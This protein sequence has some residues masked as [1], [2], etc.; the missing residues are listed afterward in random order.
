VLRSTQ[1]AHVSAS[2]ESQLSAPL[3]E[4]LSPESRCHGAT[5][6]E[7]AETMEREPSLRSTEELLGATVTQK[8]LPEP[9]PS[10]H[11]SSTSVK[12]LARLLP[13]KLA[14][15]SEAKDLHSQATGELKDATPT[16]L[17]STR[18]TLTMAELEEEMSGLGEK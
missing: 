4:L 2:P 18:D 11:Q 8:P 7:A 13:R 17:E 14:I 10:V 9:S 15:R 3:W 5:L 1:P 16:S 6:E 12:P